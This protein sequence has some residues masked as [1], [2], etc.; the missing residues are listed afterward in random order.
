MVRYLRSVVVG[1]ATAGLILGLVAGSSAA[2]GSGRS[3]G[4]RPAAIPAFQAA[5][6]TAEM[7]Y[8]PVPSCVLVATRQA[9]GALGDGASRNFIARGSASLASQGG[10]AMGCGVPKNAAVIA[11]TIDASTPTHAGHLKVKPFGGAGTGALAVSYLTGLDSINSVNVDLGVPMA[12]KAF[13]I[14]NIGGPTH[15]IVTVVGYY[16]APLAAVISSAGN[17]T[18]GSRVVSQQRVDVGEYQVI[19]DRDVSACYFHGSSYE[20]TALVFPLP[21]IN[22]PNGVAVGI[23]KLNSDFVDAQFF[24][25]VTC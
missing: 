16:I 4:L 23:I 6:R 3:S 8:V 2:F 20:A 14:I 1:A 12:G 15:V 13:T 9:G 22:N 11:T 21:M 5:G 19:F 7:H 17:L 24:L 18:R 10:S 25:T